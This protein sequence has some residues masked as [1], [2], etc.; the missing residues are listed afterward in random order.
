MPSISIS[1]SDCRRL[2]SCTSCGNYGKVYLRTILNYAKFI[3]KRDEPV[4]GTMI[5]TK[6]VANVAAT[7]QVACPCCMCMCLYSEHGSA[8]LC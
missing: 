7:R 4:K 6:M 3:V 1:E 5:G 2:L 8:M